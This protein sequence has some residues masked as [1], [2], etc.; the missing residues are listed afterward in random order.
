L[1][2]GLIKFLFK[3]KTS[4][5]FVKLD[6]AKAFDSTSWLYLLELLAALGFGPRWRRWIFLLLSSAS[7]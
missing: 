4:A 1:K 3:E 6:I 5:F 2:H 7:S